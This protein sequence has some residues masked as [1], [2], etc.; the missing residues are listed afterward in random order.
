MPVSVIVITLN[1]ER[2]IQACLET[3]RWA[4]EIILVD[5][6]S[7]DRTIEIA[8]QYTDKIFLSDFKGYSRNKTMAVQQATSEW[9]LWIDAD[10]RIPAALADE[11]QQ[12]VKTNPV[13]NGFEMPRKAIF[14]GRW[15]R[16]CGW[17]PGY[18][19]RLFRK[20]KARFS[21]LAVHEG[22]VLEGARRRLQNDIIHHTDDSLEHYLWKLNRY[23]TMAAQERFERRKRAG[24]WSILFHPWHLFIKMYFWRLGFLDGV[25]GLMLCLLSSG[26]VAAKYAKVWEL[27]KKMIA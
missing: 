17:Y 10:E 16:H 5:S 19:L 18:V 15:I 3:V 1:E 21:D 13:E 4:D 2:N 8:K 9:I 22:V 24:I 23:T 14:L 27:N 12:V 25:E 26:Y 7:T 20:D 11:I 6:H